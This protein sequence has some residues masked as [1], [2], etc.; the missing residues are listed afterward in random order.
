MELFGVGAGELLLI[1]VLALVVIGP[2][3]LPEVASQV[4]RTVADLRRQ[5][6]QLTAEFQHSLDL[7]VQE[8]QEQRAVGAVGSPAF[9]ASCGARVGESA[10][11]CASCGVPI[12][13]RTPDGER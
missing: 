7:A 5:A 1:M 2:E 8:R 13:R 10:R 9:C 3:R 4:G 11:Y 6:N 12:D